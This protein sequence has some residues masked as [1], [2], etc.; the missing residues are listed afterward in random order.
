MNLPAARLRD[1]QVLLA[2]LTM[3][4]SAPK[5]GELNTERNKVLVPL[6]PQ[7]TVSHTA[8]TLY[9]SFSLLLTYLCEAALTKNSGDN[10]PNWQKCT[11]I[12]IIIVYLLPIKAYNSEILVHYC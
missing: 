5:S 12:S 10:I 1:I 11:N 2:S 7:P 4:S 8:P 9:P 3:N 6:A